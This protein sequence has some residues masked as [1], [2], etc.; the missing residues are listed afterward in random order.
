[1]YWTFDGEVAIE[2]D[3]FLGIILK[4]RDDHAQVWWI[5]TDHTNEMLL[6]D[7]KLVEIPVQI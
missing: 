3:Q 7:L 1:V 4:I 6:D 5:L 2:P